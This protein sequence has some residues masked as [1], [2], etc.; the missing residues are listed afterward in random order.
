MKGRSEERKPQKASKLKFF[1]S[2]LM[3]ENAKSKSLV[4]DGKK[5]CSGL[6]TEYFRI[7]LQSNCGVSVLDFVPQPEGGSPYLCLNRLNQTPSSPIA[8]GSSAGRKASN[9]IV[10]VYHGNLSQPDN[11]CFQNP[12]YF[13]LLRRSFQTV[14]TYIPSR[15]GLTPAMPK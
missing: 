6:G 10:L 11:P 8:S 9:R 5:I 14:T 2:K 4:H 7:L 1:L 3:A 15:A 12:S 13:L